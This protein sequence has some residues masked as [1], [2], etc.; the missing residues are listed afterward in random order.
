MLGTNIYIDLKGWDQKRWRIPRMR[1]LE[2]IRPKW[3]KWQLR[4]TY[5]IAKEGTKE[6]R[7]KGIRR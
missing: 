7:S 5:Q 3:S 2:E 6:A 4:K 1:P